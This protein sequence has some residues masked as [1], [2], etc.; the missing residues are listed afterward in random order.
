MGDW[1]AEIMGR[2]P[3][4][5]PKGAADLANWNVRQNL[6]IEELV[7]VIEETTAADSWKETGGT[8]GSIKELNR[9]LIV[10]Q[11]WENQERVADLL[12]AIRTDPSRLRSPPTTA[13]ATAPAA[14]P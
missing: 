14:K 7:R 2:P 6:Q 10:T 13:P 9:Q 3:T 12:A 11:T 8:I 1:L 4:R 5:A